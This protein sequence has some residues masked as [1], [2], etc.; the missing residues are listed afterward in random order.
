[1]ESKDMGQFGL[2]KAAK[3]DNTAVFDIDGND[4]PELLIAD[5]NYVRAV[6]Y[7]PDPPAG[8]SPGWQVVEQ[9]NA[10]DSASKLVSLAL[11]GRHIAAADRENGRLIIMGPDQDGPDGVWREIESINVKGLAF[12]SIHAGALSGDG[13]E[14]ILAIGNDGFG[15]IRLAGTRVMLQEHAS[16]RTD[17]ERR[18]QHELATGDV[19]GDGFTDLVS[20][21]AGE[22]M[23]EL[24]TISEAGR[25]LYVTGFQVFESKIFSGGEPREYEP[26]DALVADVTGD[27]ADDLILLAH[28][29][30]LIYPQMTREAAQ[31]KRRS[32]P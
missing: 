17:V 7:E 15:L 32:G 27:G 6:R 16:W 28:D 9:I 24:F 21:D 31:A 5:R 2:V 4:R 12:H 18:R 8:I 13:S 25:L 29:R 10:A 3:A 26:N 1:M 14:N 11:L 30:V 19:N 22:Q 23:C 20:L